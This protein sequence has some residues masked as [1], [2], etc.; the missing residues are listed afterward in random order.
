MKRTITFFIASAVLL[1]S[2]MAGDFTVNVTQPTNNAKEKLMKKSSEGSNPMNVFS[3]MSVDF[4][5]KTYS[6]KF[7]YYFVECMINPEDME[8]VPIGAKITSIACDGEKIQGRQGEESADSLYLAA[9]V[10]NDVDPATDSYTTGGYNAAK[11]SYN[12]D[13]LYGPMTQCAISS[14]EGDTTQVIHSNFDIAKP[15]LYTGNIFK[16]GLEIYAPD[17]IFFCYNTTNAANEVATTYHIDKFRSFDDVVFYYNAPYVQL[18]EYMGVDMGMTFEPNKLP[19][20]T[21][22]Y[23]TNDVRGNITGNGT[24]SVTVAL[25][26]GENTITMKVLPGED[27]AFENVDY[28]KTY[29]LSVNDEVVAADLAFEDITKDIYVEINGGTEPVVGDVNQD[30][31]VNASDVTAL[32]NYIL[33][34][35][36]TFIATSDV[37]ND[38]SVNASDVTAVYN[39]I[40]GS[41]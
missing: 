22:T 40:L 28:T 27:F 24:D 36:E 32:Y 10:K 20:F 13:E 30:G 39:I 17:S 5:N 26:D 4:N 18:M 19:A 12:E 21:L 38:G 16:V 3:Q 23:F 25:N 8:N 33:N 29:T 7:D 9:Y 15:F 35:N 41:N 6:F 34:G 14:E 37:N 11:A 2:A 31:S 1:T